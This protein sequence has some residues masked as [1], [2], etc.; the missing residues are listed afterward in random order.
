MPFAA[1]NSYL[2]EAMVWERDASIAVLER[3]NPAAAGAV[4]ARLRQTEGNP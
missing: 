3:K 4:V 1:S 2:L